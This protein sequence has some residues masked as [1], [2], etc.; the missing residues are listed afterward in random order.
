MKLV[1]VFLMGGLLLGTPLLSLAHTSSREGLVV[2]ETHVQAPFD[3]VPRFCNPPNIPAESLITSTKT[4]NWSDAS[5]WSSGQVPGANAKVRV[6]A[7]QTVTYDVAS[8]VKLDCI[9]V[10]G[11][12]VFSTTQNTRMFIN[13]LMVMP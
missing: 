8:D 4:G 12:L 11:S 13:E 5:V 1:P 7:G 3:K 2:T 6:S 10:Q 9:E